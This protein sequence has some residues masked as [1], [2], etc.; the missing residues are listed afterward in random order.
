MILPAFHLQ[1]HVQPAGLHEKHGI[2]PVAL[3]KNRFAGLG[4]F[5]PQDFHQ[6]RNVLR[7]REN[8]S[9]QLGKG[10][11]FH[12]QHVLAVE[13]T[14]FAP[15]HGIVEIEEGLEQPLVLTHMPHLLKMLLQFQRRTG[16]DAFDA[17]LQHQHAELVETDTRRRGKPVDQPEVENEILHRQPVAVIQ[18][19]ANILDE[20]FHGPQEQEP[21]KT[22]DVDMI[23]EFLQ[24]ALLRRSAVHITAVVGTGQDVANHAALAG[25]ADGDHQ[26]PGPRRNQ[27]LRAIPEGWSP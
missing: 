13:H 23:P 14:I 5:P 4:H 18:P 2:R 20:L 27:C 12:F 11:F 24:G 15:L 7:L 1:F 26:G 8:G 22:H 3:A 25:P 17:V 9:Q 21:L 19:G 6:S 10:F 16:D